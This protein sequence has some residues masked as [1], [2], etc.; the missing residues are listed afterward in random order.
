MHSLLFVLA[1]CGGITGS[2]EV[3]PTG[4]PQPVTS[5]ND[6]ASPTGDTSTP[7]APTSDTGD[8]PPL[9]T[10]TADLR[11]CPHGTVAFD[12]PLGPREVHL[13]R[14]QGPPPPG[15]WPVVLLFQGSF[16]TAAW[17]WEA[18]PSDPF[19]AWHQTATIGTLLDAG[20]AVITPEAL[21][22]GATYWTTNVPPF[23]LAWSSS[24]DHDLM[25]ALFAALDGGSFP[26]V[27]PTR[28]YAGG[29]SSGGYMA[30]RMAEA[31]P[32][33]FRALA[34]HSA[35]WCTCGGPLCV[36]PRLPA[37][38]PP[39][40][41]LH[42]EEDLVAPAWAMRLYA[43]QMAEQGLTHRVVT[44]AEAGHAWL[45]VAPGELLA[46]FDQHP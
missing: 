20:Y 23:A 8:R 13:Q 17:M 27:D 3:L 18:T 21:L 6:T 9:C 22:D 46:W 45:D 2:P 12:T 10:F 29:I 42:G 30:S 32:G 1:A 25:V 4:Q 7:V 11:S 43:D 28:L 33:R 35:S 34:V 36:V 5:A 44:D 19:G 14:P 37:D 26:D 31:Y 41:F 24:P 40:L 16:F 15:G 38:H 39:T